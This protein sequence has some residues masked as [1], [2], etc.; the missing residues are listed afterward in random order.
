[1]KDHL[2]DE[3][4]NIWVNGLMSDKKA[5]EIEYHINSCS[6]CKKTVDEI[7]W[8]TR[9]FAVLP[10]VPVDRDLVEQTML[11]WRKAKKNS[12]D[13]SASSF[14]IKMAGLSR[15][16]AIAFVAIGLI[17]GF[18]LGDMTKLVINPY[19]NNSVFFAISDYDD[20]SDLS[21]PY[22]NLLM[23]DDGSDL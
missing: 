2:N 7:K 11:A 15:P 21:D 3:I 23:T 17:F 19:A 13:S 6:E 12:I 8:L 22:M 5:Q 1:M 20:G 16:I 18:L 9:S 10:K 14:Q 4:L